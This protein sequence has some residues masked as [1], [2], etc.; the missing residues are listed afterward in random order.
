MIFL[1]ITRA[2]FSATLF[3]YT[4]LFR[5]AG[6]TILA[7]VYF[8]PEMRAMGPDL[9][10]EQILPFALREFI[11]SGLLGLL[12]AGLLAAFMSTFAATT[13]AAPAYVVNDIYKRYV[14]PNADPKRYVTVSY[15]VSVAF[16]IL[17]VGIGFFIPNLNTIIQWIVSAFFGAYTASNV[18]KWYWWRLNGIGY[19]A[20]MV[21][22]LLIG[23]PLAGSYFSPLRAFPFL[24]LASATACVL[25]S[26]FT[27]P[28]DMT[29]L[30]AFYLKE[31]GR[32]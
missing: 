15:I 27:R 11:P 24:L 1:S 6:L 19:F 32:A 8:L 23:L 16:V 4:T 7:L 12:I 3:P 17:G 31:I 20:G 30:K 22:G 5:S 29:V 10:F 26:V 2:P 28:D 25:A 18:L 13:N 14:N 21:V 9:D